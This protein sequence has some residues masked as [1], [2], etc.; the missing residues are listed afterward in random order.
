MRSF[1]M[2]LV[3]IAGLTVTAHAFNQAGCSR[4]AQDFKSKISIIEKEALK[5]KDPHKKA[6]LMKDVEALKAKETKAQTALKDKKYK[7]CV[8]IK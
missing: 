5:E 6:K 2:T 3:A 8:A 7:E 1:F 4:V